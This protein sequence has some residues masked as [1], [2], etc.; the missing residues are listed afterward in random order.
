MPDALNPV[1]HNLLSDRATLLHQKPHAIA[2][3][4]W[5]FLLEAAGQMQPLLAEVIQE[6]APG[7]P[8][9]LF[10]EL[11]SFFHH[12]WEPELVEVS[13]TACH[14]YL[15]LSK[16]SPAAATEDMLHRCLLALALLP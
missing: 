13:D 10:Q 2:A 16:S 8:L 14:L 12:Y 4:R 7:G 9:S 3:D 5:N 1:L 15:Q 11:R 6:E